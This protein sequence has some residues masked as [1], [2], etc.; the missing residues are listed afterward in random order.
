M[1]PNPDYNACANYTGST[2]CIDASDLGVFAFHFGHNHLNP[3]FKSGSGTG[4]ITNLRIEPDVPAGT[5]EVAVRLEGVAERSAFGVVLRPAADRLQFSD[6]IPQ[7]E[8]ATTTVAVDTVDYRGHR[9]ALLALDV[10]PDASGIVELGTLVFTTLRSD[11]TLSDLPIG[12]KDMAAHGVSIASA[13]GPSRTP[14]RSSRITALYENRPNPF[15]PHTTIRYAIGTDARVRLTVYNVA[16]RL[17]RQLVDQRQGPGEY[18]VVWDGRD[19]AG[20]S[21]A[22]GLYFSRLQTR[23]VTETRRLVLMR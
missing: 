16:G 6:W 11:L 22:T 13:G 18:S 3:L 1:L 12:Y 8:Y 5:F 17:V 10:G 14:S 4:T 23:E 15:N 9:L 19:N 20:H 2:Q 7:A 21:V